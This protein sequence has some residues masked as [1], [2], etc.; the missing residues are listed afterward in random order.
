IK[1]LYSLILFSGTDPDPMSRDSVRQKPFIDR[2]Y[3]NFQYGRPER[4][5]R[6]IDSQFATS[7]KYVST[8]MRGD[9]TM[10]GVNFADGRIKGYGIRNPRGGEKKFYVLYVRSNKDYGKNDFKDNGDGTVTDKATGLMWMKV[11]SG[12]LKAGKNKDGKLNWQEALNWA[13]N[14]KYAGYSDWR[15][16]NVKELQSIVDYTRSPATTD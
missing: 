7:T 4:G 8:T 14:L 1:E 2:Q 6:V 15:L 12:K 9:E 13:E 16:P 3:F 5:E 10:F 11:D